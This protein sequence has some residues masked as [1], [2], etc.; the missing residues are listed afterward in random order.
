M[1]APTDIVPVKPVHALLDEAVKHHPDWPA[2]DFLGKR[3]SYGEIGDLVLRAARGFQLLGVRKGTRV[4]LCLP[5]TPYF[6]VCYYAILR[7]G[8]VVVNFNPLYVERELKHQVDDS[9]VTIMVALDLKQIYPKVAA[10][11]EESCLERIVTCSMSAILPSVK[12]L[13]FSVLKRSE[14]ADIPDDL[15]H[16]PFERLVSNDGQVR[17]VQVDPARDLAVLQYTGGT[18]GV[19]K[20][21]MLTHA[22][23]TAN[24]EQLWRWIPPQMVGQGQEKMLGVLPLFHVFAMTVVMNLGVRMAAELILLPRFELKQVLKL[25]AKKRP[26]LFPGV[27]T[28][29]TA[30]NQAMDAGGQDLSSIRLCISGGAPLPVEVRG[31]FESLTGCT[32]VEGYGLSESSPVATC[33]PLKGEAKNA[34]IGLPLAWTTIELRNPADGALIEGVD[35]RGEICIR[36]PQVMAG[37][38]QRPDDTAAV[39]IDGAL[40]TGDIGYRDADG[41]LFLVDRIKDVILCGGFNVYPRMIEEA[42]YQHPAVAEA[43]VI[44]IPD[45]YRGQAPKAFV[46]LREGA[47]ATP[48]ELKAFLTTQVSRIEMPKAVEI[49]QHLPKTMIGKLSKKELV[50]EENAATEDHGLRSV[51]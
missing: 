38:W 13:L 23:L 20:G 35:E 6:V 28:I 12:S 49:R 30:I 45:S 34:S 37:Y 42:L 51:I 17:P 11:L 21:A 7:I 43:V 18:T 41:Y 40:R 29:Y 50:A 8:G 47:A 2:V 4:G 5:N 31:R 14:I 19:P 10:I 36:G 48:D 46:R 26:T 3:Y 24:T 22:N 44:G 1:M 25:I 32:L 33:N 39:F 15:R 9:G 16:V 27:P